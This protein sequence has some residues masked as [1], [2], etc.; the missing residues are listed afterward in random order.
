MYNAPLCCIKVFV[1]FWDFVAPRYERYGRFGP[2]SKLSHKLAWNSE[3]GGHGFE[4]LSQFFNDRAC[5]LR[6]MPD[7]QV[8]EGGATAD[9]SY[10]AYCLLL[11]SE[12]G[13]NL[14]IGATL[15][16]TRPPGMR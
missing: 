13:N 11:V 1:G 5:P 12:C 6:L 8:S 10:T 7:G 2:K 15:S 9:R 3:R 4:K 16:V 14:Q